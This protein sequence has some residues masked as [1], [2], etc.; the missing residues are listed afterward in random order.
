MDYDQDMN[1]YIN[2]K[3]DQS[4]EN[5]MKMQEFGNQ[6]AQRGSVTKVSV[7]YNNLKNPIMDEN[8]QIIQGD[9]SSSPA[10]GDSGGHVSLSQTDIVKMKKIIRKLKLEKHTD[11]VLDDF[12]DLKTLPPHFQAYSYALSSALCSNHVIQCLRKRTPLP[13]RKVASMSDQQLVD[14][15]SFFEVSDCIASQPCSMKAVDLLDHLKTLE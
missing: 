15:A 1:R 4:Y 3:D 13:A 8:G 2:F 11:Y 10:G 12:E 14:E 7:I 9:N 6:L 5:Y